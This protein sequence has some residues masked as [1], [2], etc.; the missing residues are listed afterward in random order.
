MRHKKQY[1]KS[2]ITILIPTHN[3]PHLLKRA[4]DYYD[5]FGVKL[6]V[7]DSS[8]AIFFGAQNYNCEY[9]HLPNMPIIEKWTFLIRKLSTPYHIFCTDDDLTIKSS[10]IKCLSFLENHPDYSC[11]LGN[12]LHYQG[13]SKI[14]LGYHNSS[15]WYIFK[16]SNY[17]KKDPIKRILENF[18]D[19]LPVFY[20]VSRTECMKEMLAIF[21]DYKLSSVIF[22]EFWNYFYKWLRKLI[23]IGYFSKGLSKPYFFINASINVRKLNRNLFGKKKV[24]SEKT[25]INLHDK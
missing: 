7:G 21:F 13:D 1:L 14:E 18:T 22:Y 25:L 20:A 17:N 5:D 2:L 3:R 8:E 11:A 6:I 10:I 12:I 4:L 16:Q 23:Y 9:H 19:T 15:S 24:F